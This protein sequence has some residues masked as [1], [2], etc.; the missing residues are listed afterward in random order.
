MFACNIIKHLN[1]LSDYVNQGTGA[2]TFMHYAAGV[3]EMVFDAQQLG[4]AICTKES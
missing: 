2:E 3:S 1:V 4:G